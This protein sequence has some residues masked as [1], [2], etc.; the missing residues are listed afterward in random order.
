MKKKLYLNRKSLL[1]LIGFIFLYSSCSDPK[2]DPEL[3]GNPDAQ[4]INTYFSQIPGWKIDEINTVESTTIHDSLVVAG[5]DDNSTYMCSLLEQK[6]TST[7]KEFISVGTN[8]GKIWPGALL[9]P[10]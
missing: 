5:E 10:G 9:S 2:V 7:I 1:F 6:V 4:S 8:F 3:K